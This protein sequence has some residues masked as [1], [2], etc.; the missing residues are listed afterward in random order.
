M[1]QI[2]QNPE[3][4]LHKLGHFE[5]AW[6]ACLIYCTVL[7]ITGVER[8]QLMRWVEMAGETLMQHHLAMGP[9]DIGVGGKIHNTFKIQEQ[10]TGL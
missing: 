8:Y 3:E 1:K 9:T 6:I 10:E 4:R 7:Q 2:E 5:T